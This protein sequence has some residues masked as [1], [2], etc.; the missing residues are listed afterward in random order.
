MQGLV[1]PLRLYRLIVWDE[2]AVASAKVSGSVREN[3]RRDR[4]DGMTSYL[5]ISAELRLTY[6]NISRASDLRCDCLARLPRLIQRFCCRQSPAAMAS[7]SSETT[8]VNT[9][10]AHSLSP[11][12]GSRLSSRASSL[13]RRS[14][15]AI[16]DIFP[17]PFSSSALASLPQNPQGRR[18]RATRID[19]IP[20][21]ATDSS[22][23]PNYQS[24]SGLPVQVRIPKKIAT[25]IK[26]EAK[27][28]FANERSTH[29]SITS[30]DSADILLP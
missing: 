18:E 21:V 17:N 24:I 1:S 11:D 7:H 2:R 13:I 8:E 14:A 25:P 6:F 27:V 26:V 12:R 3:S 16:Q 22:G 29:D 5:L 10:P 15:Y 19:N 30:Q 28:W 9:E 20:D 23:H 4:N